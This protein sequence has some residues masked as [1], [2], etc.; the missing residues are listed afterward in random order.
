MKFYK[1]LVFGLVILFHLG[2]ICMATDK[3]GVVACDMCV[4]FQNRSCQQAFGNSPGQPAII[5][6]CTVACTSVPLGSSPTE[7]IWNCG[8]IAFN[9]Y[10]G[11]PD[12]DWNNVFALFPVPAYWPDLGARAR[13]G[14]PLLCTRTETCEGCRFN[15]QSQTM[16]C[17]KVVEEQSIDH[18]EWCLDTNGTHI[19]CEDEPH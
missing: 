16:V 14:I 18:L 4:N 6:N 1:R 11:M 7:V 9:R 19:V 8:Q 12:A 5:I 3:V 17:K 15:E 10:T 2:C 13:A